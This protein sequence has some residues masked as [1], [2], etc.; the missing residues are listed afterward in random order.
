[1]CTAVYSPA[2][3]EIISIGSFNELM[4]RNKDGMGLVYAEDGQ[5]KVIKTLTRGDAIY[6]EYRAANSRG[7][8]CLLHFRITTHGATIVENCHP[9]QLGEDVMYIHNGMIPLKDIPDGEVDSR[10][11]AERILTH[12][13]D[14]WFEMP[15]VRKMVENFING[16]KVALMDRDG[17]VKI[18]NE[19]HGNWHN[20]AWFSNF[21]WRV[22]EKRDYSSF[23]RG[24]Y[25]SYDK[26]I[27]KKPFDNRGHSYFQDDNSRWNDYWNRLKDGDED[28]EEMVTIDEFGYG[29]VKHNESRSSQSEMFGGRVDKDYDYLYDSDYPAGFSVFGYFLCSYCASNPEYNVTEDAAC[30]PIFRFEDEDAK[31]TSDLPQECEICHITINDSS[32]ICRKT[33]FNRVTGDPVKDP[34]MNEIGLI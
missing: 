6:D 13:P 3:E 21:S 1:M 11:F 10:L 33:L 5:F 18:L 14:G 19:S 4:K 23:H 12:L 24:G 17:V 34:E 26:P 16:S 20:G 27:Y 15:D 29:K 25:N 30:I 22:Y 7:L 8:S 32:P 2:S 9:F 28:T 31:T